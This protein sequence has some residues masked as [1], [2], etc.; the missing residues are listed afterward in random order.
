MYVYRYTFLYLYIFIYSHMHICMYTCIPTHICLYVWTTR[1][2]FVMYTC[3]DLLWSY[4]RQGCGIRNRIWT[5]LSTIRI[6]YAHS[7]IAFF[8]GHLGVWLTTYWISCY[9]H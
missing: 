4:R 6:N 9:T 8:S 1:A 3:F 5:L 2:Y 7:K